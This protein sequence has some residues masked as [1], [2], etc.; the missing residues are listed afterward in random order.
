MTVT[1]HKL[2]R[3]A[4]KRRAAAE[5]LAGHSPPHLTDAV[6]LAGYSVECIL[7]AVLLAVTPESQRPAVV[8]EVCRGRKG[9]DFSHLTGLLQKRGISWSGPIQTALGTLNDWSTDLRYE[10]AEYDETDAR[11]FLS[12]VDLVLDWAEGKLS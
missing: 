4:K 6:Y 11:K 8:G 7:K 9:H 5:L 2:R 1:S 10:T 3:A 12:R